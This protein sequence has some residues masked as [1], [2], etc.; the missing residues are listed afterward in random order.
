VAVWRLIPHHQEPQRAVSHFRT[1]FIALGWGLIGDLRSIA[2]CGASDI[3]ALARRRYPDLDND[4]SA[5]RSLWALYRELQAGDLVLIRHPKIRS[6]VMKVTGEYFYVEQPLSELGD[7]QHQRPAVLVPDRDAD[8]LWDH[9]GARPERGWGI[10][11]PL[12]KCGQLDSE[13]P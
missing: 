10:R 2:A 12:V 9:F 11:W 4:A 7:Y 3:G 5:G 8:S 13:N 6:R 1:G